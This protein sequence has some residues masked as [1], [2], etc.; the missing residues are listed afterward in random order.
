[1]ISD[2]SY[3]WY[4]PAVELASVLLLGSVDP[5]DKDIGQS[6][7]VLIMSGVGVVIVGS[8]MSNWTLVLWWNIN[9]CNI[10]Y[11]ID[12]IYVCN[13]STVVLIDLPFILTISKDR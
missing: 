6:F 3:G 12:F 2:A 9:I 8:G 10:W 4:L 13:I 11:Y 5:G 1:M 7:D